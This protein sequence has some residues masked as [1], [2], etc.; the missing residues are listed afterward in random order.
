MEKGLWVLLIRFA[1]LL[2]LSKILEEADPSPTL[3]DADDGS[4]DESRGEVGG[5]L[6]KGVDSQLLLRL[7]VAES[8]LLAASS[9]TDSTVVG[10]AVKGTPTGSFTPPMEAS[11]FPSSPG[12]GS[13]VCP[14]IVI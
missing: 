1:I 4:G 9:A 6:V 12:N 13:M 7:C 3:S 5:D 11:L 8:R 2:P 10:L 14:A